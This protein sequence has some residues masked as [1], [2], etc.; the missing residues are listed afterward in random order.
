MSL[1][2]FALITTTNVVRIANSF[3]E[4]V[5]NNHGTHVISSLSHYK[6]LFQA[7]QTKNDLSL[8]HYSLEKLAEI[9]FVYSLSNLQ[10]K[11]F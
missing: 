3:G 11:Y 9:D 4:I 8:D 6:N 2:E 7:K 1:K 10:K 5:S